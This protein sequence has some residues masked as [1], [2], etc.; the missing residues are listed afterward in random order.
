MRFSQIGKILRIYVRELGQGNGKFVSA[1]E[2]D[3]DIELEFYE[4]GVLVA[5]AGQNL[6]TLLVAVPIGADVET[7]V[8]V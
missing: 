5:K 7:A 2:V 1:S 8:E 6:G 4:P 3:G